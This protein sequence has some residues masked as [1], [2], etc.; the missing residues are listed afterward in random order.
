[1]E[2]ELSGGSGSCSGASESHSNRCPSC[3]HHKDL[4]NP[5]MDQA[6]GDCKNFQKRQESS[7]L[8]TLAGLIEAI[9]VGQDLLVLC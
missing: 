7:F 6:G 8:L 3:K 4:E 9:A 2:L 5:G 1:M